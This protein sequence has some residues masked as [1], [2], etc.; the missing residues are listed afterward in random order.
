MSGSS[1]EKSPVD[2]VEYEGLQLDT[3]AKDSREKHLDPLSAP[4]RLRGQDDSDNEDDILCEKQAVVDISPTS[5]SSPSSTGSVD[6]G[7]PVPILPDKSAGWPPAPKVR[8]ICG[9]RRRNFWIIFGV[10]L[11][12]VVAAA[13]IGGVVGGTRHSSSSGSPN[14]TVEHKNPTRTNSTGTNSTGT[15]LIVPAN[16]AIGSPLNV[17]SQTDQQ[18]LRMYF[19]SGGGIIK[20]AKQT[21][22][23]EWHE[24]TSIFTDAVNNTGLA[25]IT[26]KNNGQSWGSIFYVSLTQEK[27][28]VLREKRQNWETYGQ[29][30]Y[31]TLSNR[32]VPV[33]EPQASGSDSYRMAAVYSDKFHSGAGCRLFYHATGKLVQEM[34]WNQTNDNWTSGATFDDALPNSHLSATIDESTQILRLFY[35]SYGNETNGTQNLTYSYTNIT[36]PTY[37]YKKGIDIDAIGLGAVSQAGNSSSDIAAVSDNGTTYVYYFSNSSLSDPAIRE[38]KITGRLGSEGYNDNINASVTSTEHN[39]SPYQP[40]TALKTEAGWNVFWADHT[41]AGTDFIFASS[42]NRTG[43]S[44]LWEVSRPVNITTWPTTKTAVKLGSLDETLA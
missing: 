41:T 34:I 17:I 26:W 40:L 23:P 21:G 2:R 16:V 8:R 39:H 29:W 4:R 43:Y 3:R 36:N 7:T 18:T 20:E 5:P 28:A 32:S 22:T 13:V 11:A 42:N 15:N 1:T 6:R 44:K 25:T 27:T 10:I 30:D 37:G 24:A 31:G 14:S 19:Q 12:I 9:V 38:L 33:A 35:Y